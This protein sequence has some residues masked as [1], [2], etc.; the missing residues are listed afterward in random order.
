MMTRTMTPPARR[1]TTPLRIAATLLAVF[2]TPTLA[3]QVVPETTTTILTKTGIEGAQWNNEPGTLKEAPTIPMVCGE[4]GMP[5]NPPVGT[6]DMTSAG[7]PCFRVYNGRQGALTGTSY[8]VISIDDS[9][10]SPT[11][12]RTVTLT[13]TDDRQI[14]YSVTDDDREWRCDGTEINPVV[15][16]PSSPPASTPAPTPAADPTVPSACPDTWFWDSTGSGDTY[17]AFKVCP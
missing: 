14:V 5:G 10:L 1:M 2:A 3:Q 16:S 12:P 11:S 13:L 17:R 6:A 15:E 9:C 7:K 4:L 8:H